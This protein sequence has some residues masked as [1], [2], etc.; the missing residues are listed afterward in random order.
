MDEIRI[1]ECGSEFVV[2]NDHL[3]KHVPEWSNICHDCFRGSGK[4]LFVARV[5]ISTP[6]TNENGASCL[7]GDTG[8]ILDRRKDIYTIASNGELY[9]VNK[10]DVRRE[11]LQSGWA[12]NR[13]F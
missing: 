7:P 3:Q 8:A 12:S 9:R 5:E 13:S 10:R 6:L 1:C 2:T 11:K 4:G